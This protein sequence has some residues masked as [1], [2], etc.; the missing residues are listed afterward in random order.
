M[1]IDSTG[2]LG[3]NG[4]EKIKRWAANLV[5][6][7]DISTSSHTPLDGFTRVEVIQF[8]GNSPSIHAPDSHAEVDIHLGDYT[9]KADLKDKIKN[10]SFKE[11][12]STIIP[13]GLALLNSKISSNPPRKTYVFVVTDGI[14]DSTQSNLGTIT[15]RPGTLQQEAETLKEK[16]NVKVFAIGFQGK[17]GM[18][19][20]NLK[21]IASPGNVIT[22]MDIDSALEKASNMLCNKPGA[23]THLTA[24]EF[25]RC[26]VF[27]LF[28][29]F[30]FRSACPFY[31]WCQFMYGCSVGAPQACP[32]SVLHS[33]IYYHFIFASSDVASVNSECRCV[34][35][36]NGGMLCD[37]V[38]C[39]LV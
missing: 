35:F 38:G 32:H 28:H 17:G 37:P 20:A 15:P 7:F 5:N 3:E 13:H 9:N 33:T 8:W 16:N 12:H 26:F 23:S 4:H 36:P 2:T 21:T 24:G 10:L 11:G 34:H 19:I 1:A 30:C 22:G 6:E 27:V 39:E 25:D 14:D 31:V 29:R 18:D